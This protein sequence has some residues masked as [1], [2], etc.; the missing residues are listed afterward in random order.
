VI[1]AAAAERV[2]Y[3]TNASVHGNKWETCMPP[4]FVGTFN[5]RP[6]SSWP[7]LGK[8]TLPDSLAG[9]VTTI[10]YNEQ[11]SKLAISHST[12][13]T[14]EFMETHVKNESKHRIQDIPPFNIPTPHISGADIVFYVKING[15]FHPCFEQLKIRQV[16]EGSDVEKALAT[17]SSHAIQETMDKEQEKMQKDQKK[18]Q[19]QK[20]Q[21]SAA[22]IQSNQQQQ[23]QLQDYCPT[24]TYIS[25]VITYLAE[26]VNFQVVRPNPE[27]ELEGLQCMSI[28]IDDN[29]PKIFPRRHVEFLDKLKGHKRRPDDQQS[30]KTSKRKRRMIFTILGFLIGFIRISMVCIGFVHVRIGLK[31]SDWIQSEH[32]QTQCKP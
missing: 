6:L 28:E 5:T 27:P 20:Q 9:D 7:L 11:E 4:I 16:L 24:G 3:S 26:V 18:Q 15:N 32:A 22:S 10:G 12:I 1:F 14:Q 31:K 21:D 17:V 30:Q 13:T 29:F 19:K 2:L 8:S 23:P 25:M